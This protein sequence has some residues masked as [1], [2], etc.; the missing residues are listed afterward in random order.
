MAQ[1]SYSKEGKYFSKDG[2]PLE[3]E[4]LVTPSEERLGELISQQLDSAGFK[5]DL[6]SMDL[7]AKDSMVTDWEFDLAIN[8]HGGMGADPSVLNRIVTGTGL[9]SPL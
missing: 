3:I 2:E 9:Y 7:K 4:L 1:M 5:V 6:R 8:F